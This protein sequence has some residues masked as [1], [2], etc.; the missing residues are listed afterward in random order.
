MPIILAV[1]TQISRRKSRRL[2]LLPQRRKTPRRLKQLGGNLLMQNKR[3]HGNQ[4]IFSNY[5]QQAF[6]II[7]PETAE[8]WLN[9]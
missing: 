7:T 4:T 6:G 2:R 5:N 1:Q 9:Q 8:A 3:A